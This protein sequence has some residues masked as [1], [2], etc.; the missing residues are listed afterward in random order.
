MTKAQHLTDEAL[1]EAAGKRLSAGAQ[2]EVTQHLKECF[3]CRERYDNLQF[4]HSVFERLAEVGLPEILGDAPP[5][6]SSTAHSAPLLHRSREIVFPWG[7]VV[8]IISGCVC[9]LAVL[10]YPA[11]IPQANA[12]ELLAAAVQ[13]EGQSITPATFR[14]QAGGRTCA[15]GKQSNELVSFESSLH[16]KRALQDVKATNWGYGNPLSAKTYSEWRDNLH[17]RQDHVTKQAASWEIRTT[18]NEGRVHTASLEMRSSDYHPTKLTLDFEDSEEVSISETLEPLPLPLPTATNV[19]IANPAPK[20]LHVDD[21]ADVLEIQAWMILHQLNADSGWEAAVLR[22][23]SYMEVE[24]VVDSESR[25]QQFVTAFAS[26]HEIE[27]RFHS[28]TDPVDQEALWP[29]RVRA[30]GDGPGLAVQWL[31]QQFPN[32]DSRETFVNK[33]LRLSRQLLG[34]A[35]FVSRLQERQKALRHCSLEKDLSELVAIEKLNVLGLQA[36]LAS[37]MEPLIGPPDHPLSQILS[38]AQAEQ[39]DTALEELLFRA[40]NPDQAALD[41]RIQMVRDSL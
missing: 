27:L 37:N 23:G 19:A 30:D 24:A 20:L 26:H 2:L 1:L 13:H 32:T 18:T 12:T 41:S 14:L 4:A 35:F 25:K 21:P 11:A 17:R 38:S 15:G 28:S 3:N 36:E 40:S 5:P 33:T 16:C 6:S 9:S 39:L 31:Q 22:N 34:R 29:D 7:P 10:F 8:A